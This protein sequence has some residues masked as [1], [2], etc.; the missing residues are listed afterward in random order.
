MDRHCFTLKATVLQC[1]TTITTA[2]VMVWS[3]S[4]TVPQRPTIALNFGLVAGPGHFFDASR[5]MDSRSRINPTTTP[6]LSRSYLNKRLPSQEVLQPGSRSH[7]W[8]WSMSRGALL[9]GLACP[10]W[11]REETSC[12]WIE[13]APAILPFMGLQEGCVGKKVRGRQRR[14]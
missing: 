4:P 7:I 5:E 1:Q 3:Q 10:R 2:F 9:P 12:S 6:G 14:R 11:K 13:G 8:G